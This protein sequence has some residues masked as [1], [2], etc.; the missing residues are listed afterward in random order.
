LIIISGLQAIPAYIY[1][2][3]KL[4]KASKVQAFFKMT[5]PLLTPTL[6]FVFVTKFIASFK[7]FAP[8]EIMTNGGPMGS[9][10]VLSYWIYKVGRIGFNYGNAMAG[11]VVLTILIG[12]F[13]FINYRFFKKQVVY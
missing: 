4:D 13:T 11:A 8:I 3:A 9:S 7:V 5:L 10:M 6:S 12:V 2:A 1:E